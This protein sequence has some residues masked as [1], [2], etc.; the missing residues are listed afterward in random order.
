MSQMLLFAHLCLE[1]GDLSKN[2]NELD[3]HSNISESH[4]ALQNCLGVTGPELEEEES[5]TLHLQEAAAL[6]R[7]FGHEDQDSNVNLYVTHM[8]LYPL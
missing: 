8:V 6:E 5:H 1:N 2:K 3:K 4:S 7:S